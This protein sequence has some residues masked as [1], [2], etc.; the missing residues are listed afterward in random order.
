MQHKDIL[1]NLEINYN[2]ETLL[3]KKDG[4]FDSLEESQLMRDYLKLFNNILR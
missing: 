1:N 2:Y 3:E 4:I